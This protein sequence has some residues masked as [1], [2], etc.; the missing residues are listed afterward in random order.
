MLLPQQFR[1]DE[2]AMG[3]R[4]QPQTISTAH[5]GS[6]QGMRKDPM[7]AWA[8]RHAVCLLTVC[9]PGAAVVVFLNFGIIAV[10]LFGSKLYSCND[11]SVRGRWDCVGTFTSNGLLLPR[12]W[13]Q[14]DATFDDLGQVS[15]SCACVLRCC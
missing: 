3:T 2:I 10:R 13:A 8:L 1:H 5:Q 7:Q 11:P 6:H 9:V 14:P 4:I 15:P 12:V